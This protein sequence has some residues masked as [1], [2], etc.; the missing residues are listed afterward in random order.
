[1]TYGAVSKV[2][3]VFSSAGVRSIS[4]LRR[5]LA[6]LFSGSVGKV[7]ARDLSAHRCDLALAVWVH[8]CEALLARLVVAGVVCVPAV[9]GVSALSGDFADFFGLHTYYEFVNGVLAIDGYNSR[10]RE[11]EVHT[12]RL[13]KFPGLVDAIV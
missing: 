3:R 5:N 1:M 8:A 2:S 12:G 10:R 13:A 4:S 9:R 11:R 6:D 7:A